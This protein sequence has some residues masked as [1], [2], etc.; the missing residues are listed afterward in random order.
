MVVTFSEPMPQKNL[1]AS[2]HVDKLGK[3]ADKIA[4]VQ[5]RTPSE[6]AAIERRDR[7]IQTAYGYSRDINSHRLKLPDGVVLTP[8]ELK[9]AK[10]I[11]GYAD[12]QKIPVKE[13]MEHVLEYLKRNPKE[14]AYFTK[15]DVSFAESI[16]GT[17]V[18]TGDAAQDE[19]QVTQRALGHLRHIN[20]CQAVTG[21]SFIEAIGYVL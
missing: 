7:A 15:S 17:T 14:M 1:T 16:S 11:F 9:L 12:E 20:F 6:I 18:P 2:Q 3:I 5:R 10:W 19:F 4:T 8:E 13:A 21:C